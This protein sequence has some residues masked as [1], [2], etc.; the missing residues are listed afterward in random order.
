ML[1]VL[2][3]QGPRDNVKDFAAKIEKCVSDELLKNH[4]SP[5]SACIKAEVNH[6]T[7]MIIC[8]DCKHENDPDE[9]GIYPG[10]KKCQGCGFDMY[11]STED[12]LRLGVAYATRAKEAEKYEEK[13]EEE[14]GQ[15]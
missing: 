10:D 2:A 5:L 9:V 8:S 13:G 6:E 15:G 11:L 7:C 4:L 3:A 1:A 12:A 14:D